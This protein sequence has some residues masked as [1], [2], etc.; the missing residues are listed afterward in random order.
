MT[1]RHFAAFARIAA[2]M[3]RTPDAYWHR[4]GQ[5]EADAVEMTFSAVSE[6][7]D[8]EGFKVTEASP[9]ARIRVDEVR[10]VDPSRLEGDY[11]AA[12]R[13]RGRD[14][15]TVAG[16]DYAVESC[17]HDGHDFLELELSRR[18]A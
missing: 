12:F 4:Q 5:P 17:S 18:S 9:S 8:A 2:R 13:N 11:A 16:V 6:R 14:L 15:I 1:A 10:R 7:I 3:T